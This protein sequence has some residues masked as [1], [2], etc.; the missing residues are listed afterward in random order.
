M[1][2]LRQTQ[3]GMH[4]QSTPTCIVLVITDKFFTSEWQYFPLTKLDISSTTAGQLSREPRCSLFFP[5]MLYTDRLQR[6][7]IASTTDNSEHMLRCRKMNQ[8]H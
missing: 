6:A 8:Q 3:P 1:A 7:E 2:T 5:Y 4:R